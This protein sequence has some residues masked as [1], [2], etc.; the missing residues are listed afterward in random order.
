M[1]RARTV[2]AEWDV[3]LSLALADTRDRFGRGPAQVV[4]W[5][6]DPYAVTGVYLI[7]AVFIL[8]RGGETAG[9]SVACAVI[10]FQLIMVT[11]VISMRSVREHRSLIL[12]LGFRRALLPAATTLTE[13]IGFAASLSLLAV[14]M[15]AYG[16]APTAAA[17]WILPVLAVNV[18]FA[19]AV[20]YPFTIFGIWFPHLQPFAMSALRVLYFLAP[21]LIALSEIEG[22]A[23]EWVRLNPLTGI[24]EAY[25]DALLY[26]HAPAA[27][28]LLYPIGFAL[29]LLAVFVP[30]FRSEQRHMAKV[31]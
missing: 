5:L 7:F 28:E 3:L 14:M 21:G 18:L 29:V 2:R 26:G 20:S 30:M 11:S 17:L 22:D 13:L 6:L 9:L 8:D 15:A 12:N 23:A 4:K 1:S 31:A 24:F 16:I 10:P 25:R 27:W 19:L